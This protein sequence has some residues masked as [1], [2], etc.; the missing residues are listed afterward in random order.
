MT[1]ASGKYKGTSILQDEQ[2]QGLKLIQALSEGQRERAILKFSKSGNNNLTEAFK[3]NV[4]LDYA[5][6]RASELSERQQQQLLE[7][8]GLYNR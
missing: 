7:L 2:D 5:G 3:D 6:I 8:A 1:R 4:V